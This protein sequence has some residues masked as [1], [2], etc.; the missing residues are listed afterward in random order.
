M[1]KRLPVGYAKDAVGKVALYP[2]QRVCEA[3]RLVFAKFRELWS[4]RQTFHW[5][6]DHDLELPA[7]PIQGA[8]DFLTSN[9]SNLADKL[10]SRDLRQHDTPRGAHRVLQVRAAVLDGRFGTTITPLAA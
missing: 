4:V 3:I 5:F 2:D 9:G 6:R 7:N 1:F 8:Q 10:F